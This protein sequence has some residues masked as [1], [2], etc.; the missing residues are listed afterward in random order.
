MDRLSIRNLR[1]TPAVQAEGRQSQAGGASSGF[2]S[3]DGSMEPSK[4]C[5][6]LETQ[7]T[8]GQA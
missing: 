4:S 5:L 7:P 1:N 6:T 2:L 3:L 8:G